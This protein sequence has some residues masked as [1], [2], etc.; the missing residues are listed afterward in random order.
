MSLTDKHHLFLVKDIVVRSICE[1]FV[2]TQ[3]CVRMDAYVH[4]CIQKSESNLRRRSSGTVSLGFQM[5]GL[6]GVE[7]DA[8]LSSPRNLLVSVS[9]ALGLQ[10]YPTTK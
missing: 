1:V 6:T 5:D 4:V 7:L 9:P 3:V 2:H 8:L 10:V